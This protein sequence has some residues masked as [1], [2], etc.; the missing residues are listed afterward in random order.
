MF[1]DWSAA[2]SYLHA[3][4]A[5]QRDVTVVTRDSVTVLRIDKGNFMARR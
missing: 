3:N 5:N 2:A 1:S 4:P